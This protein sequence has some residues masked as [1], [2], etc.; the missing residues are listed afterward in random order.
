LAPKASNMTKPPFQHLPRQGVVAVNSPDYLRHMLDNLSRGVVSV[1]LRSADD[2]ERLTRTNAEEVITPRADH[3]WLSMDFHSKGGAS[4]AQVSFTSGTEGP[5]KAVYLSHGNLHDVVT[6]LSAAMALTEEVREYV[7]VPVYHSFGYGRARAVLNAGGRCF[8]PEAG[9]NLPELR[10]ML[11][12]GEINAISAV[13]SLWHVFLQSRDLFGAEL[14]KVR[15]IEIGSQ[16]MSAADKAALRTACPNARIVQ[17]YGLTEASRSTFQRVDSVP[18]DQLDAVGSTTG[19]VEVKLDENGCIQIRGPH[20]ALGIDDG[21]CYRAQAPEAWLRTNDQGRLVKNVLYF[22]GRI[23]D[24]INLSGIKLSPDLIEGYVREMVPKAGDFGVLKIAD[25][26]RG[27]AVLVALTPDAR[28]QEAAII[29]AI[30]AYLSEQG[31]AARGAIRTQPVDALPRTATGK[32]QR[33]SIVVQNAEPQVVAEGLTAHIIASLGAEALREVTTTYYDIGGDSL[34][35]MEMT[36]ALERA[37]GAPPPQWE[38][39]PLA[40]LAARAEVTPP[41]NEITGAP[42]LP[43]GALNENPQE[44]S[45]WQLVREDFRTNDASLTHQGFLMLFVHRF[46]NWRMDIGPRLL[47]LPL[48]VLYRVLNKLTQILFGMKLDYTVKVGRRVKLEH[49]GGMI[50]GAREIGDDVVLRQNTTLGIRSVAEVRAK[51]TL[52]SRVDVGAGA[53]IVG[54]IHIGDNSIIGANSVVFS[55][56]PEGSVVMGVPGR[57]IGQNPR[58]NPS[59]LPGHDED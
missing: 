59:P 58:Q 2:Q 28:P 20:V 33:K 40:D 35:H 23:D 27:D 44:I 30:E 29:A 53:V 54:D 47:R 1:P 50:L 43:T 5:A 55:N 3:G 16:F 42:P 15:W 52:G 11:R 46:G 37:F 13:P 8:I 18:Y 41:P 38:T 25:A 12:A 31:L 4:L 26:Q 22:E 49:F 14:D 56:V 34:S 24:V 21:T 51:P 48:T 17:H 39:I 10:D 45:F 9:F 36:M 19:T 57:I 7:G 32:L 6:R